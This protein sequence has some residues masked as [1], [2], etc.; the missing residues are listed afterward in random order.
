MGVAGVRVSSNSPVSISP[1]MSERHSSAAPSCPAFHRP[2][3]SSHPQLGNYPEVKPLFNSAHQGSGR[4]PRALAASILAYAKHIDDLTPLREAVTRITNKHVALQVLPEH[5][6][7]VSESLLRAIREVLG[8]DVATDE[9]IAAWGAA[10]GELAHILIDTEET[11]YHQLETAPGGWRGPRK[12]RVAD[13]V[14]ETGIMT[15]FYLEPVDGKPI[16]E[17]IGL[18]VD[19]NEIEQRRNQAGE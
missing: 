10:Y 5:Y 1:V 3:L 18:R 7:L 2:F 13:K 9:V 17:H 8:K 16:L 4:Q 6:P 19:D 15:S 12:F 14:P 11:I